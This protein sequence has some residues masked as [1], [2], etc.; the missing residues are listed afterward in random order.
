MINEY[1]PPWPRGKTPPCPN[2]KRQPEE[3]NS[4]GA[5]CSIVRD[6]QSPIFD[7]CIFSPPVPIQPRNDLEPK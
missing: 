5:R 2:P 4:I 1:P 6:N 3:A 7:Q